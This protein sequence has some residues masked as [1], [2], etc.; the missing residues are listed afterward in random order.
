[1]ADRSFDSTPNVEGNVAHDAADSG[2]P[3]KLGVKAIAHGASPT[4]V[5][6]DDRSDWYGNRHGIPWVIGGHPNVVTRRDNYT[7]AQTNAAIVTIGAGNKIVVTRQSAMCDNA[8][9]VDVQ[10]RIGFAAATTPTG[11]GVVLSHP[12]IAAGSGVVEGNGSGI[13]GVGA[14]GED[15]R[16]TSEVPTGGSL[17]I[18]TTY[19]VVPS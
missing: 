13:L 17:D 3:V 11:A 7:A 16:I 15:L 10:V 6:A 1:M 4:A 8:N 18:V 14:D 5:A 12:G 9:S 2:N 19:Y